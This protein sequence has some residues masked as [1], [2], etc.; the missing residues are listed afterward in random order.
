MCD[1]DQRWKSRENLSNVQR[2]IACLIERSL[3]LF[4][5]A[6]SFNP[7]RARDVDLNFWC[8]SVCLSLPHRLHPLQIVLE[9]RNRRISVAH[10]RMLNTARNDNHVPVCAAQGKL[11]GHIGSSGQTQSVDESKT[12]MHRQK[13]EETQ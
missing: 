13:Q 10:Y 9:K 11:P 12:K 5:S 2:Y 3:L 1:Q 4:Q 6:N 8:V 7:P